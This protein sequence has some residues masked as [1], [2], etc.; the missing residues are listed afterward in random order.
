MCQVSANFS[1]QLYGV[2][3][4]ILNHILICGC[5]GRVE[6]HQ[7]ERMYLC[8]C[9]CMFYVCVWLLHVCKNK[10]TTFRF[11][12]K[13]CLYTVLWI[14]ILYDQTLFFLVVCDK[15]WNFSTFLPSTTAN[16]ETESTEFLPVSHSWILGTLFSVSKP[17]LLNLYCSLLVPLSKIVDLDQLFNYTI[18]YIFIYF[19]FTVKFRIYENETYFFRIMYLF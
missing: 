10:M 13:I 14:F 7:R 1:S 9:V 11:L 15:C 2:C 12:S 19:I 4:E 16:T 18:K 3:W 6:K 17:M 5:M 8:T